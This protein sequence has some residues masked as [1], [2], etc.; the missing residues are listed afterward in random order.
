M[1]PVL[2]HT[3]ALALEPIAMKIRKIAGAL[4]A[5]LSEID[6]A[7]GLTA[8]QAAA[9]RQALLDHQV[10]FIKHQNLTPAQY[11]AFAQAMGE[12]IEYPFVR[13]L[14]GYPPIIEIKKLEHETLNFG[15]IWHSHPTYLHTAN[16][17]CRERGCQHA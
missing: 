14:E 11:L 12:P 9:V 15:V 13:G 16:T 5:E 10:I 7:P 8:G 17:S 4:G 3:F 1:Y 2:G 6:L